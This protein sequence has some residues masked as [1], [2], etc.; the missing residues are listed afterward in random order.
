M[1][2]GQLGLKWFVCHYSGATHPIF[3]NNTSFCL[4]FCFAY[5]TASLFQKFAFDGGLEPSDHF[6]GNWA[7]NGLSHI[8]LE[9]HI[10]FVT[11]IIRLNTQQ[12]Q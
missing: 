3:T 8:N 9:P 7:Q 4:K 11:H 10:Q 6:L 5:Q 12:V 1:T 2:L